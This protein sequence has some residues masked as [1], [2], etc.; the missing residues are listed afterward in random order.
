MISIGVCVPPRRFPANSVG[1]SCGGSR[2]RHGTDKMAMSRFETKCNPRA[3]VALRSPIA[4]SRDHLASLRR[5]AFADTFLFAPRRP[6]RIRRN[7]VIVIARTRLFFSLSLSCVASRR[8][9]NSI[10]KKTPSRRMFRTL[11]SDLRLI[12][13]CRFISFFSVSSSFSSP[14][15]YVITSFNAPLQCSRRLKRKEYAGTTDLTSL[16]S[17]VPYLSKKLFT[18]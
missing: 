4:P 11:F 5:D 7:Y 1:V 14:L 6:S 9:A 18:S 16:C 8:L 3:S 17:S 15:H 10:A 2:F 12:F 13:F